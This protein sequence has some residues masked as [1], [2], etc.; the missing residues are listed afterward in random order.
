[1][2][3]VLVLTCCWERQTKRKKDKRIKC[4]DWLIGV[5]LIIIWF[6]REL[7][8]D[9]DNDIAM[10]CIKLHAFGDNVVKKERQKLGFISFS[11]GFAENC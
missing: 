8:T 6:H 3:L 9:V 2:I 5:Y 11:S 7:L 10:H 4:I 1:M